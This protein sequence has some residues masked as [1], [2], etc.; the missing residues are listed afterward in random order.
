MAYKLINRIINLYDTPDY[1]VKNLDNLQSNIITILNYLK[2]KALVAKD[3]IKKLELSTHSYSYILD[4]FSELWNLPGKQFA[5]NECEKLL[6]KVDDYA[7]FNLEFLEELMMWPDETL[8]EFIKV[9]KIDV[10]GYLEIPGKVIESLLT[11]RKD[12]EEYKNKGYEA[13][14]FHEEKELIEQIKSKQIKEALS[15]LRSLLRFAGK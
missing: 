13:Y 4:V 2:Q 5:Y 15:I 10:E 7:G 6:L 1:W 14:I 11:L 9:W 8:M 12:L 3:L